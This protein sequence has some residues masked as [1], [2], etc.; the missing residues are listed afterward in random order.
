MVPKPPATGLD[1]KESMSI[2]REFH[3]I[4]IQEVVGRK[5]EAAQE[6]FTLAADKGDGRRWS[7][8]P[9]VAESKEEVCAALAR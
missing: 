9:G 5:V 6:E 2:V 3:S 7:G 8:A 1:R 4:F